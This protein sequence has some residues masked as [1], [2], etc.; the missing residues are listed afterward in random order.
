MEANFAF[1]DVLRT[2]NSAYEKLNKD[3][4]NHS[5]QVAYLTAEI[6]KNLNMDKGKKEEL[7]LAA[8]FHDLAAPKTNMLDSI[9]KYELNEI[10]EHCIAGYIFFKYLTPN[11]NISNYILYH[12]SSY[13]SKKE[14][15]N[16]PIL[17]ESNIIKLAD[18]ISVYNLFNK[19]DSVNDILKFIKNE[20][21]FYNEEVL[22]EFLN[23]NAIEA[24]TNLINEGYKEKVWEC[25]DNMDYKN[26]TEKEMME[27]IAFLIDCKCD[28][29]NFHSLSVSNISCILAKYFN[30]NKVE[31]DEI[32]IGSLL[33]DIGKIVIPDEILKKEGSLTEEEFKIMKKHVVYTYEI[34]KNLKNE[35]VLNIASN[36]HEKLNGKGYPRGISNLSFSE[37]IVAVADIFVALVEKRQYKDSFPKEKVVNIL[38]NCVAL[39]EIDG[40]VVNKVIENYDCLANEND[41]L[42]QFYNNKLLLLKDEYDE[43]ISKVG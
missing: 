2:L 27:C 32:R 3:L 23:N 4:C 15:A 31:E 5:L 12:H 30:L 10:N 35:R 34:L 43:I 22:Y 14:I 20:S 28:I 24:F 9:D 36:H 37:K 13:N 26:I 16:I 7:V 1:K 42:F 41:K 40:E 18:N 11:S 19:R 33:H 39:G 8:Y 17:P 25:F 29:T 21:Y 38:N 6:C